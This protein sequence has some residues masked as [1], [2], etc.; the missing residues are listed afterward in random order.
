MSQM[1]KSRK[2]SAKNVWRA[3]KSFV[4]NGPAFLT[5]EDGSEASSE[6]SYARSWGLCPG[7]TRCH[8]IGYNQCD[9]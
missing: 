4:I 5:V 2:C 6:I 9:E 3:Q 1:L 7:L 8:H